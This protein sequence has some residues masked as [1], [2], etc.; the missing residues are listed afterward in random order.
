MKHWVLGVPATYCA[1][2]VAAAL[3]AWRAAPRALH[4][5]RCPPSRQS[6]CEQAVPQ[7]HTARQALHPWEAGKRSG[8]NQASPQ[9]SAPVVCCTIPCVSHKW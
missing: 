4:T 5:R 1:A 2:A 8:I 6:A 7:Y 9:A 3:A